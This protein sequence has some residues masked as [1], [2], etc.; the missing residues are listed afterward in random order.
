LNVDD[1]RTDPLENREATLANVLAK[2]FGERLSLE[3]GIGRSPSYSQRALMRCIQKP[4][5]GVRELTTR[6]SY[7][8]HYYYAGNCKVAAAMLPKRARAS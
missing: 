7:C 8:G 5:Y 1:L 3:R 2:V 4:T 6:L